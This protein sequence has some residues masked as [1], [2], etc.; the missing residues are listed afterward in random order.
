MDK[1]IKLEIPEKE[2]T[3]IQAEIRHYFSEMDKSLKRMKKHDAEIARLKAKSR[4]ML[5]KFEAN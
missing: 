3:R 1:T 2:A 5:E 4:A